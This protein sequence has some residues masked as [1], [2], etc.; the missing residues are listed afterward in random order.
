MIES[1]SEHR[2]FAPK[3]GDA[4]ATFDL[5]ET[6]PPAVDDSERRFSF[7]FRGADGGVFLDLDC[8]CFADNCHFGDLFAVGESADE[9][10]F[11]RQRF[12]RRRQLRISRA[13]AFDFA[14]ARRRAFADCRRRR[15]CG[16]LQRRR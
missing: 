1:D 12:P 11:L 14:R 16:R 5:G 15:G 7:E 10:V 8:Q 3:A 2:Q 13:P 6:P 4:A 9:A